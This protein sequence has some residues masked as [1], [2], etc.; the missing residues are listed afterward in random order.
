[1]GH[2]GSLYR[3]SDTIELGD[4]FIGGKHK[5]KKERGAEGKT[6][7]LI[8]CETPSSKVGE[9]L[10]R[11]YIAIGSLKAFLLAIFHGVMSKYLQEYLDEFCYRFNRLFVEKQIPNR[12]LNLG[13]ILMPF[14]LT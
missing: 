7:V 8:A 1:M 13:V 2:R 9:W 3:L 5:G 11:V 14:K 12:L 4:A 10:P 6:P